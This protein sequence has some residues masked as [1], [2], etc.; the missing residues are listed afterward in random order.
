M[1]PMILSLGLLT[2]LHDLFTALW[3]GGLLTLSLTVAPVAR[4]MMEKE[5][6]QKFMS[7][8]QKRLSGFVYVSIVGLAVTGIM[9]G[10]RNPDFERLFMFDTTFRAMLSVKHIVMFVMVALALGRSIVVPKLKL[11]PQKK[12]GLSMMLLLANV[13]AGVVILA[14]SGFVAAL[15]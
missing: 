14:L 13:V 7:A 4:S 11:P 3:V 10:K 15:S 12:N 8:I 5:Q 1:T 6:V 2:F 9:L